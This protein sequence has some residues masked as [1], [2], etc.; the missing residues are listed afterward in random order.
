MLSEKKTKGQD[1]D[2]ISIPESIEIYAG[3]TAKIKVTTKEDKKIPIKSMESLDPDIATVVD[4]NVIANNIGDT[5]IITTVFVDEN[6]YTYTTEVSVIAGNLIVT[7]DIAKIQV[8]ETVKLKTMVS[9]GVIKKISY[10]SNNLTAATVKQEGIYGLVYGK[11]EG[12]T[13]IIITVNVGNEIKERNITLEVVS[14]KEEPIPISNPVSGTTY[15]DEDEWKGSRVYFGVYE[16]DNNLKNGKEP[17]LWRVLE[18]AEDTIL[19]LSEYGLLCKFYHD[20]FEHVTWETSSL[21]AWLNSRFLDMAFTKSEVNAIKDTPVKNPDNKKYGSCGGNKT[22]DKVYLLSKK[23][24]NNTTY[25]FQKGSRNK[26]ATR[27]LK[28]TEYALQEGY[29]NK[30]N[31]NTCWWLRSPGFTNQYASYV[32]TT[33]NI[34]DT[35]FVGRRNDAVRPVI[36]VK[37]SS[38]MFGDEISDGVNKYPRIIAKDV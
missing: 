3:N 11:A 6:E 28:I 24:A 8:G 18:V 27:T 9:N 36:R 31:G 19:L 2:S 10:Q 12:S 33:G 29:A 37:R 20:T 1:R 22:I 16:Q 35:Y 17:I 25:G 32:F 14:A 13:T 15:T 4:G 38:V 21:R 7:P 23:E 30:K 34:T 26:S 5:E